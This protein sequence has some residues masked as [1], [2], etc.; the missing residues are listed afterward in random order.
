M[1]RSGHEW[2]DLQFHVPAY[3]AA[4]NKMFLGNLSARSSME[5]HSHV[6]NTVVLSRYVGYRLRKKLVWK[7]GSEQTG[8]RLSA[9]FTIRW[10]G[11]SI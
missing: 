5:Y 10:N 2:R 3:L 11:W 9:I 4:E 1:V 8:W 6:G 7:P